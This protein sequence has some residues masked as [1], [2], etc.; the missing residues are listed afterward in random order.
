MPRIAIFSV[1]VLVGSLLAGSRPELLADQHFFTDRQP[2]TTTRPPA[3][4]L[5]PDV[6]TTPE[7]GNRLAVADPRLDGGWVPHRRHPVAPSQIKS[8]VERRR[9]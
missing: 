5:R 4:E 9:A 8:Q 1:T 7:W 6:Q 3:M 2:R